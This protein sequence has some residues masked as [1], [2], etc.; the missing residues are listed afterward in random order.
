MAATDPAIALAHWRAVRERLYR[1][2]PQS[3]VPPAARDGVPG[4]PFRA[5][6]EP[7]VR[8][9]D[10][11]RAAARA[12]RVRARA[13]QQR[14]GHAVVLARRPDRRAVRRAASG[15][16]RCSG[17]PAM[18][19]A[20]SSRSA[21]RRM[22]PRHTAPAATS[23]MRAKSA[24]LGGDPAAGTLTIDFN[25]AYPAVVRV[26]SR[27]GRARWRRPRTAS[28]SPSARASA[29]RLTRTGPP[30]DRTNGPSRPGRSA[31]TRSGWVRRMMAR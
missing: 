30:D 20:C 21:T 9:R 27:A 1:Q 25:F 10:R 14:R 26:R 28:T 5:R 8:G 18:R 2:H 19:A 11:A 31:G 3:P 13:A 17:W 15:R 7:P 24:D 29:S 4:R 16:C 12:R 23:S 22:A 6:P